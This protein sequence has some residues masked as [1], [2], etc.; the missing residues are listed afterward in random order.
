LQTP[1]VKRTLA[2]HDEDLINRY[3]TSLRRGAE[4]Y[5]PDKVLNM[6]ET[7]WKDIQ[8]AGKA[9]APKGSKP[10]V[11]LS[12]NTK[13]AISVISTV[14]M[15]GNK[16]SPLDILS[17]AADRL[18]A[19]LEPTVSRDRVTLSE[20][21]SMDEII[22]LKYLSWARVAC[23]NAPFALIMDSFTAHTTARIRNKAEA[24]DIEI[25]PVRAGLTGEYQPLDRSC[26]GPLKKMSQA[27]WVQNVA[28]NPGQ[29]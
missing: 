10:V 23:D 29:A 15:S 16:F 12:G 11:L 6:D 8:F 9:V 22:M 14:S 20:N 3:V 24:L 19:S 7:S 2:L 25:I 4:G 28:V 13:A 27:L 5:G 1:S 18:R 21:A 26:F 17:G